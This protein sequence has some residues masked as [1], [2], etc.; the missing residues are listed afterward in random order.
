[1]SRS[2][3]AARSEPPANEPVGDDRAEEGT[4]AGSTVSAAARGRI[5]P[6]AGRVAALVIVFAA[7]LL[8]GYARLRLAGIPLERDEGE[9]AYAGQLILRGIPPYQRAYNMKFPGTYYAYSVIL[10]LLGSTPSAIRKGLLLVNTATILPLFL[11]A[12]RLAGDFAAGAAG[13]SFVLLA[14]S[15]TM[16]GLFAHATHFVLLPAMFGLWLLLRALD[17]G[18]PAPLFGSGVLLG[19]AVLMKQHAIFF[20]LFGVG[21]LIWGERRWTTGGVRAV[22]RKAAT[23]LA[24]AAAPLVVLCGLFAWQGVLRSFWFW[25][26]G[27]ALEYVSEVPASLALPGL[28]EM[29]RHVTSTNS[30]LWALALCGVAAVWLGRREAIARMFITGLLVASFFGICPG[31]Y[32]RAHYFIL[33]TPAVALLVGTSL[34]S[35]KG[36][37]GR[38]LP[39]ELRMRGAISVAIPIVLLAIVAG[40]GLAQQGE[41]LY[42]MLPARVS[43]AIYDGNPFPE[44]VEI[45]RYLKERTG[46]RDT[47]AV[48]GSEPEIY[49]YAERLS[50]TGYMYA[51]PLMERQRFA[52]WMQ[53]EMIREV[54]AAHPAYLVDL[55]VPLSWAVLP[56][57]DGRILDWKK[58]Y[59]G[60]CYDVVGIVEI[61]P[62]GSTSYLWDDQIGADTKFQTGFPILVFKR[63]DDAPCAVGE[64]LGSSAVPRRGAAGLIARAP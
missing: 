23:L 6:R 17:S 31:F 60:K 36:L 38:Y 7:V 11:I 2:K 4:D 40:V 10:A 48:L 41:I 58:R 30:V 63:N 13:A 43:R 51:Y 22:A 26:F 12:R 62:G 55:H 47:V 61:L 5:S 53:R 8:V 21:L 18:R 64:D 46:P 37:A 15:T 9:Y 56:D 24:G 29:T 49:F 16:M 33:M 57:S 20:L 3:R 59:E 34:D 39:S 52:A 1:M 45:G 35:I 25:T 54:E 14:S 50:A 19:L 44:A 42:T 32:F 28:L 27:Y